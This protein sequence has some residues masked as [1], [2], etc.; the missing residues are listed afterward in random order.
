MCGAFKSSCHSGGKKISR[1]IR[2]QDLE[3]DQLCT[4]TIFSLEPKHTRKC[5]SALGIFKRIGVGSTLRV[6]F[7]NNCVMATG[8]LCYS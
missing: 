6:V 3:D 1:S 4:D 2:R 5:F 8:K 7:R